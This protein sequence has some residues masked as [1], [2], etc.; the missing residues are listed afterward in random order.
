[1]DQQQEW[2]DNLSRQHE[3]EAAVRTVPPVVIVLDIELVG[4]DG[5]HELIVRDEKDGERVNQSCLSNNGYT[6]NL[7]M[8]LFFLWLTA[9]T[10]KTSS[11]SLS[12]SCC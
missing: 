8:L 4:N 5:S 7:L 3:T 10:V 1:M 12:F 6:V 2:K 11:I 9:V